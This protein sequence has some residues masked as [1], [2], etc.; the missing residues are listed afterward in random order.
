[1]NKQRV[2][3]IVAMDEE[4]GIG[5]NN[6]LLFRIPDD[7]KRV[8]TLTSGHPLVMGRKTFASLGRLLPNRSHIVVTRDPNSVKTLSYQPDAV[9]SSVQEGIE[10]A[11]EFP[12]ADEIFIFGGGQIYKETIE[13]DLVDRLYLTIVTGRYD[14]DAFFPKYPQF[15]KIIEKEEREADGYKYTFLTVEKE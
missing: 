15:T 6:D 4:R 11:K 5:K 14:A 13:Q 3:I 9:V 1:M 8:R 12:G 2:S 7:A 10:K